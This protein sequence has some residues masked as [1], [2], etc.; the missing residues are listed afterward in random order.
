MSGSGGLFPGSGDKTLRLWDVASGR[1]IEKFEGHSSRV[2][3][4][5]FSPDGKTALSGSN[6][7]TVRLW[8]LA[9]GREIGKFIGHSDQVSAVAFAPDGKTALSGSD[10]H[11][12]RLWNR[13][14]DTPAEYRPRC[15]P[16]YRPRRGSRHRSTYRRS[17]HLPEAGHQALNQP[18]YPARRPRPPYRRALSSP[19]RRLLRPEPA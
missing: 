14:P 1:E 3:S 8:D 6:D 18:L 19:V 12:L 11:A 9:S 16:D 7:E 2:D 13:S 10:D 4:V 17:R 5:A 15:R